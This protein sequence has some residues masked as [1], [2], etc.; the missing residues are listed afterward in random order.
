M[1]ALLVCG[2]LFLGNT[3][4]KCHG[5]KMAYGRGSPSLGNPYNGYKQ[6]GT[7][8]NIKLFTLVGGFNP[9]EKYESQLGLLFPIYGK[10]VPNHQAVI[11]NHY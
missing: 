5:R 10:N 7:E 11:I 4:N 6:N 8:N 3:Q 1:N 2:T 9:S